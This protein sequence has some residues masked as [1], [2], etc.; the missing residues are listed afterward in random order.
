MS[1]ADGR[2]EKGNTVGMETRFQPGNKKAGKYREEYVEQIIAH[3]SEPEPQYIYK[4]SYYKDGTLKSEEPI[5]LPPKFPTFE[6]FAAKLGV[7]HQTLMNWCEAHP[8][9]SAAY[10]LAKNMQL[11]IAKAGG[12]MKQ[13]DGNFTKFILMNDHGLS[14][15]TQNDTTI[16]FNV[17]YGADEIDEESN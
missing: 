7:T 8:R 15:K 11:G 5:M 1:K 3:F 17:D 10:G 14:E 16:T 2:F 13:Y 9:F 4:R 12:V 6:G